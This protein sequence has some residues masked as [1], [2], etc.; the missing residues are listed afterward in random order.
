[1]L[2]IF[3][4]PPAKSAAARRQRLA[5]FPCSLGLGFAYGSSVSATGVSMMFQPWLQLWNSL[6]YL[7]EA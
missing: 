4:M 2:E 3:Q 1:M 6:F 7:C 5:C